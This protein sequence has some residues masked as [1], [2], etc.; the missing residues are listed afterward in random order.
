M[1]QILLSLIPGHLMLHPL[2]T[3]NVSEGVVTAFL[4]LKYIN[5]DRALSYFG[6]RIRQDLEPGT[7]QDQ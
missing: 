3:L 4:D 5:G 7:W 6:A 2:T 1:K